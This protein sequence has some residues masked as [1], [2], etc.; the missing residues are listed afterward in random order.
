MGRVADRGWGATEGT[1]MPVAVVEFMEMGGAWG[2]LGC[3]LESWV[4]AKF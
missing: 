4:L 1:V 2:L 3:S